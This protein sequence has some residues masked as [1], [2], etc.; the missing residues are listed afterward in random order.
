MTAERGVSEIAA[1]VVH[2]GDPSLTRASVASIQHGIDVP[3]RV[4]V[5]D[6][7]P[8]RLAPLAGAEIIGAGRNV[9]FARAV[10]SA[11]A[12]DKGTS[13]YYWLF[14]NDAVAEE[15]TLRELRIALQL[16]GGRALVSSRVVDSRTGSVWFEQARFLPWRLEGR[17]ECTRD[18]HK[19]IT[20]RD[21][22]SWR[23]GF[24]LSGCSLMVPAEAIAELG[25]LNPA[26]FVYGEDVDLS[27]KALRKGWPLVVA[28]ESRVLHRSSSG[29]S[30]AEQ[31]RMKAETSVQIV[32][33]HYR[34]LLPLAM[35]GGLVTGCKRAVTRAQPW[36]V[37][38]RIQGYAAGL[39]K[40]GTTGR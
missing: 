17:H 24:Y 31:E 37:W 40:A 34:W 26:L 36:W 30:P 20:F 38:S 1:I 3:N 7:G 13:N 21:R 5:V 25:G 19:T 2:Y 8:G 18:E 10:M 22:P 29:S 16:F 23:S 33:D 11:V 4:I 27:F 35:A 15:N 39:R 14:N 9:G 6:N 12:Y 32:W 28:R